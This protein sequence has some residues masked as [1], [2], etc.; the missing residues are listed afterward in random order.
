M[1]SWTQNSRE[2][3]QGWMDKDEN[4]QIKQIR[5]HQAFLLI[6]VDLINILSLWHKQTNAKTIKIPRT[7]EFMQNAM[8]ISTSQ[9]QT[10]K[11]G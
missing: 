9:E 2:L 11:M 10:Q 8:E 6:P 4:K 7:W 1:L 5:K 3:A